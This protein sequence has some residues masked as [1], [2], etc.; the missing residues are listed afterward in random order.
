MIYKKS[1]WT[2]YFKRANVVSPAA[3]ADI[4]KYK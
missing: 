3:L 2:K 1:K 4:V